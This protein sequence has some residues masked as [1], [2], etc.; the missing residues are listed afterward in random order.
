MNTRVSSS[1]PAIAS[2]RPPRSTR[3]NDSAPSSDRKPKS[4]SEVKKWC[5]ST[6]AGRSRTGSALRNRVQDL[7][8][9]RCEVGLVRRAHEGLLEGL[10]SIPLEVRHPSLEDDSSGRQHDHARA[11]LLDHVEPVRAEEDHP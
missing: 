3:F 11:Q 10:G 4:N 2:E 6:T 8:G 5:V 1:P 7:P 9:E